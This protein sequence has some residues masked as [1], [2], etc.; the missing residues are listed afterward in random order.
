MLPRLTMV[1]LADDGGKVRQRGIINN[2]LQWSLLYSVCIYLVLTRRE[3][4]CLMGSMEHLTSTTL[5]NEEATARND[6]RIT[7]LER[8]GNKFKSERAI[9]RKGEQERVMFGQYIKRIT[10][11][12]SAQST[13]FTGHSKATN[14][15]HLSSKYLLKGLF[16]PAFLAGVVSWLAFVCRHFHDPYHPLK[17]GLRAVL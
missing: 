11:I 16:H 9:L 5:K 3:S 4:V 13:I 12:T 10:S 7:A 2:I 17:V 6:V 1:A 8:M 15:H 14:R